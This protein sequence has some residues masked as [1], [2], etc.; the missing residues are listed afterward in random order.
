MSIPQY[1]HEILPK[2]NWRENVPPSNVIGV[3]QEAILGHMLNGRREDCIDF[4]LGEDMISI[5]PDKLPLKRIPGLSC[6]L[7]GTSFIVEHFHFLPSNDG[8]KSWHEGVVVPEEMVNENNYT[9]YPD[10][11]VIGWLLKEIHKYKIPYKRN[12]RKQ[13]EYEEFKKDVLAVSNTKG[14][15]DLYLEEWEQLLEN[16]EDK[17]LRIVNVFGETRVNHAPTM[18]NF[19]HYTIDLYS[20]DNDIKPIDNISGGWKYNMADNFCD[21][22]RRKFV[23]FENDSTIPKIVDK[24]LWVR[25]EN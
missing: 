5:L 7:L 22:L 13:K 23:L 2:Q 12:F 3:C 21:Y 1:P 16:P 4:T 8:K 11:T 6:C 18:L 25:I 14:I 19:W 10:V 15:V 24:N 20:I 17:N 9:Y